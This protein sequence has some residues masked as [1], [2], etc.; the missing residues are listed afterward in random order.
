M[1]AR[2]IRQNGEWWVSE[3]DLRA[4]MSDA[5]AIIKAAAM[6]KVAHEKGDEAYDCVRKA[7]CYFYTE[8]TGALAHNEN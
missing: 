6:L 5:D 1:K 7:I 8:L 2:R 4:A 3:S